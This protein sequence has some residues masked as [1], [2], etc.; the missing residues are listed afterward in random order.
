MKINWKLHASNVEVEAWSVCCCS[1]HR[2]YGCW[3]WCWL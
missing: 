3:S 2:K 1:A